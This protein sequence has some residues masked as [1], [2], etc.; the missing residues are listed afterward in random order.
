M[1]TVQY[2]DRQMGPDSV[3]ENSFEAVAFVISHTKRIMGTHSATLRL[4]TK[5]AETPGGSTKDAGES[6]YS[7]ETRLSKMPT[8]VADKG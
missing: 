5:Q 4:G 1:S 8:L 2:C 3:H 7:L 6:E